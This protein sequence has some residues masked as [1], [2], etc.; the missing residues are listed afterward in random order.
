MEE[1]IYTVYIHISPSQKYYVGITSQEVSRRWRNGDGYKTQSFYRAIEKYGWDNIQHEIVASN[2][3]KEEAENF[4]IRLINELHSNQKKYGYNIDRGGSGGERLSEETKRK[5]SEIMKGSNHPLYG[6]HLSAKTRQKIRDS[7]RGEKG[8]WYG[9]KHSQETI[10]KMKNSHIGIKPTEKTREILKTQKK[11]EKNPMFG[12]VGKEA[13][14]SK[15][16]MCEDKEFECIKD[17]AEYYGVRPQ[18]MARWL[19]G[20]RKM[21]QEFLDK[22]LSYCDKVGD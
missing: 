9:K 18:T 4:E 8:Y 2:L 16:V 7:Q 19:R 15:K 1:R 13:P 3:T 12:K 20:E 21:P 10:E 17:C 5:L 14:S 11:G 22:D 6:K